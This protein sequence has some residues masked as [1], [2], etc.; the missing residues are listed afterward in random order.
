MAIGVARILLRVPDIEAAKGFYDRV[1]GLEGHSV[2]PGRHHYR[3]DAVE[4]ALYDPGADGDVDAEIQPGMTQLYFQV[5]NLEACLAAFRSAGGRL[6]S[7][8]KLQPWGERVF[9]GSDPFGH[10]LVFVEARTR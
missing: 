6:F 7:D 2:S 3:L 10:R 8:I 9:I 1:L 4:L 5:D